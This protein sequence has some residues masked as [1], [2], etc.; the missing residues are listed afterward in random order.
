MLKLKD[1]Y[2]NGELDE[3][4]TKIINNLLSEEKN[5]HQFVDMEVYGKSNE[6]NDKEI[7]EILTHFKNAVFK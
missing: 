3:E 5:D 7:E 1:D 6:D 4:W 2:A